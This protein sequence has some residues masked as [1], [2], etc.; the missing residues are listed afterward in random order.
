MEYLHI[1]YPFAL[2]SGEQLP[3]LTI[4]YETLGRLNAHKDN[5]V[6]VCHAFT[7][8]A[9]PQDWWNGLFGEGK[10]FSQD[11]YFIVCANMLGSCYGTTGPDHPNPA[12][13]KPYG[14]DFPLV[15]TRDMARLHDVLRVH[16]GIRRIYL[17]VG[18][19]MG[20][21]QLVEWAI[22]QPAV[23]ER[24]ALMATNARHSPWGIAFNEAQRMALKSDPTMGTDHPEAGRR[25]IETARAI[26]MLSYRHYHTYDQTQTETE[27]DKLSNFKAGTYQQ[28][29]GE[30][31]WHRFSPVAYWSLSRSMDS[32]N[33]G[34]KR[35]SVAGALGQIRAKTLVIG[36]E[37]DVLFPV[38]EQ[39]ELAQYI[40]GARFEIIGSSY[41]H[42]GFLMENAVIVKLLQEFLRDDYHGRQSSPLVKKRA[43][44]GNPFVRP[45][46]EV[47]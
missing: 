40:P 3:R 8:N 35:T 11:K 6:W 1:D 33:V 19:S 46:S 9:K 5:V 28:Y 30:K 43:R 24:I 7:G 22:L 31:L 10:L 2:E 26:A 37:S 29:Q 18:G 44:P 16:L 34:R 27:L 12:T 14:L 23:F 42:D 39:S 32:H 15:T 36:I 25:G 45:G 21:Q 38:E 17:G 41:G 20:G 13:G 4:A 47:F